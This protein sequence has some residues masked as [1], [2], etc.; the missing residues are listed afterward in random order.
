MSSAPKSSPRAAR[1]IVIVVVALA[2]IYAASYLIDPFLRVRMENAMNEKLTDYHTTLGHAHLQLLGGALTLSN[3][4]VRQNAHP[5]PAVAD[6]PT[7]YVHIQW[8]E[9]IWLHVVADVT[10]T[11]PRVHIDLPQLQQQASAKVSLSKVGWQ[12]A[13]QAVYPFKINRMSIVDGD[14]VYVDTDPHHALHVTD[15]ELTADNIRNVHAASDL[16][17]SPIHATMVALGTGRMRLDGHANFLE[18]P[19]ASIKANYSIREVPLAEFEPEIKRV[20]FAIRGGIL[21]SDG[22][23]EYG[24]KVERANVKYAFLDGVDIDYTHSPQTE[25]AEQSRMD[26]VKRGAKEVA[27]SRTMDLEVEEFDIGRSSLAYI[28]ETKNPN[29]K[30]FVSNLNA[31]ATSISNRNQRQPA[32]F[33]LKGNLM[34]TGATAISGD[35]RPATSPDFDLDARAEQVNLVSL[36]D[37]LRAYENIGVASGM[38]SVYAQMGVREGEIHGYVKPLF[39]NLQV[40]SWEKDK[41]KPLTTQAYKLLLGGAAHLFKNRSTGNVATEIQLSGKVDQ[42][43]VSTWQAIVE[44][45]RNAFV[46]AITPGFD[47]EM[48]R[49]GAAPKT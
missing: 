35:F 30:I 36:N 37:V 24:P 20:N 2:A 29:Y 45:L 48:Q 14:V 15:L 32:H 10:L 9:L 16:Y 22:K 3:L 6:L 8:S 5:H 42:P 13:L 19:F 23:F 12:G 21:A 40:Y 18:K 11:R 28:D 7:L 41:R 17:P 25:A 47:R 38:F 49:S 44:L 1:W 33:D 27:D 26:K 43:N 34:G 4:V 46:Q 31:K 39:S